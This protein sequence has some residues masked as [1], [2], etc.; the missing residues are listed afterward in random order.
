VRV[1]DV[2]P[3]P[4][5]NGG[6]VTRELLR[7]G[8]ADDWLLRIS[9]ADIEADGP[10]SAFPGITR[11]FAVLE[12]AGV[13]LDWAEDWS[14]C[15]KPSSEALEFDGAD[16]PDCT[17][18]DGPTRDLNVM[19]RRAGAR[20]FVGRAGLDAPWAGAGHP[21]G[22]FAARPLVLEH[23]GGRLALPPGTLAWEDGADTAPWMLHAPADM[24]P[25]DGHTAT[26]GP[27]IAWWIALHPR[28]A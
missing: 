8:G 13:L 2:A 19:V 11:W 26:A 6:G 24:A 17:L 15:V 18:L 14:A 23:A 7:L 21:R 5:K 1:D 25:A 10:F 9:V 16:A 12:G 3:A 4:W 20:A 27:P 22:V 28:D